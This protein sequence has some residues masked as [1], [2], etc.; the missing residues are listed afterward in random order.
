MIKSQNFKVFGLGLV[1]SCALVLSGCGEDNPNYK[2]P[3][4]G[5][6]DTKN[7]PF[8]EGNM[9]VQVKACMDLARNPGEK[10]SKQGCYRLGHL[11]AAAES[12][13]PFLEELSENSEFESVKNEAKTAIEKIKADI[14]DK[15]GE[16]S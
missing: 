1:M 14:A 9:E 2:A 10:K 12:A 3:G 16:G 11:G 6:F 4:T 8:A 7:N 13:I 5:T 15:A